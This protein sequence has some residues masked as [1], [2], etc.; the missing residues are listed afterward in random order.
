MRMLR[1]TTGTT[2]ART[3]R[4][5]APRAR[6][7]F[8]ITALAT[9]GVAA[10]ALTSQANAAR[11]PSAS[12]FLEG[13]LKPAMQARLRKDVPGLTITKVTCFVP[14]TSKA[15]QG[16]CT[17]KFTVTKYGIKGTFQAQGKLDDQSRLTWSTSSR[18]CTDLSGRR[19]SCTGETSSGNG[20]ISAQLAEQQLKTNGINLQSGSVKVKSA[21]CVGL[22]SK[23]WKRGKF[24]DVYAQ[25]KCTAK[26]SNGASYGVTFVMV[27]ADGYNLTNVTKR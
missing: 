15:V 24:D 26:A 17:A 20:L 19:A 4:R 27:G 11:D 8:A 3:L 5:A 25:L 18:T 1:E 10:L 14:T 16:K 22:K 7:A 2:S 13:A 23:K 12:A 6:L 9:L 21:S